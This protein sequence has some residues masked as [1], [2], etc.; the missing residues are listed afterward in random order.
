MFRYNQIKMK[1]KIM[2]L[3]G[4][5]AGNTELP[6]QFNEPV[7]TDLIKKAV[8]AI[9]NNKRQAYGAFEDAGL[10]HSGDLSR[11]RRKYRGSYGHG[12]SRVPRK[13]LSRRGTQMHWV[14]T[15]VPGTVGGRKAH[16]PK[17]DK[18]WGWKL[19]VTEKRKAIRS[20]MNAVMNKELVIQRGH[21]VPDN[22]PFI[23]EDKLEKISKTKELIIALD[24]LGFKNELA[25]AE[26]T[27]IRSG[28]GK[29]RGRKR[30]VKKSLL[31]VASDTKEVR[32]A[33]TNLPG[34]D[35]VNIKR[36]NSEMLAPGTA[37]GR[38]TIFT[39]PAL[40]ELK[41]GLFMKDYKGETVKKEKKQK[42][43]EEVKGKK[44]K[45]EKK[46]KPKKQI[47]EQDKK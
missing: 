27:T 7:R 5:E 36:L 29:I 30:V 41:K 26:K 6:A 18:K 45:K 19:N 2:N 42:K 15:E 32:K 14:G 34:I 28:L 39:A 40:D 4:K 21:K 24:K 37:P 10:L 25:R 44:E 43:S 16:P 31:I 46:V 3:D 8:L 47:K 20:A 33:A 22:Y 12:I 35:V 23:I 1:I 17:A 38:T 9:K 13:I 11:R